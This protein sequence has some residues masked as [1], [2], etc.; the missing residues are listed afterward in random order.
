[1]ILVKSAI[2]S[3]PIFF[4]LRL[5][6]PIIKEVPSPV[7]HGTITSAFGRRVHPISKMIKF[8]S[9][10]DLVGDKDSTAYAVGAGIVIYAGSYRGY[11]NLV[12][13]SH[14][15]GITTHYAH[16]RVINC[17]VGDVIQAGSS[18]GEIGSTGISTAPHLHF[19]VRKFG[20]PLD[21]K[22]VIPSLRKL[23]KREAQ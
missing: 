18:L 9:G 14:T 19:E 8:H 21:P 10:I 16:L 4:A 6:I 7:K 2:I 22:R 5:N 11:G 13:I 15:N 1:M 3:L 23:R 12:V 17:A 20:R